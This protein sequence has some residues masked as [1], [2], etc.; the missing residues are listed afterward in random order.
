MADETI[1]LRAPTMALPRSGPGRGEND[2]R[3][4]SVAIEGIACDLAGVIRAATEVVQD[5][6]RD[7]QASVILAEAKV[8]KR[9]AETHG[10]MAQ[11]WRFFANPA[12]LDLAAALRRLDAEPPS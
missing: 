8:R 2:P 1:T 9:A 3:N 7:C 5:H 4:A 11:A 12:V 10:G 6:V